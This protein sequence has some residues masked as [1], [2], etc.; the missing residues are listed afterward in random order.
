MFVLRSIICLQ[1][2]SLSESAHNGKALLVFSICLD[3]V[4][5]GVQIWMFT[6]DDRFM[7]ENPEGAHQRESY[8]C[9]VS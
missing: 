8:C 3:H 5:V 9:V 1:R 7:L 4:L 2:W 6:E